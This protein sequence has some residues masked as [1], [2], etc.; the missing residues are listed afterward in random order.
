MGG[1]SSTRNGGDKYNFGPDSSEE[2]TV[3]GLCVI[4]KGSYE[5]CGVEW[6]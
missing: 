1:T 5:K 2:E 3:S 4:L 6:T